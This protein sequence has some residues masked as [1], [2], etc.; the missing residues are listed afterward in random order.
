MTM[1]HEPVSEAD[2]HAYVDGQLDA[3]RTAAVE[4]WLHD[5]PEHAARVHAWRQIAQSLR[6]ALD[7]I[8][9]EPIPPALAHAALGIRARHPRRTYALAAS[10]ALVGLCVG[11]LAHAWMSATAQTPMAILSQ[12]AAVAHAVYVPEVRHP[13]EVGADQQAHLV[14]WLS[15]RVGEPLKVPSLAQAGYTLVGGRLL[16][17]EEGAVAQFMFE[18]PNADRLTMYV[19][20]RNAGVSESAFKFSREGKVNVF[21]WI[22][23]RCAYAIAGEI[24]RDSLARVAQL[25][26]RELEDTSAH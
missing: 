15:K 24:D 2:L 22:D 1:N 25:A 6:A 14:A 23:Q 12:R 16:P 19:V 5:Q 9:H 8:T 17:G 10:F 11:W 26:Y 7:P 18:R 13:V 4:Q 3:Q 20:R 21:Y